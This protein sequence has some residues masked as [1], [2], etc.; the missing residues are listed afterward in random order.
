MK[1]R[2]PMRRAMLLSATFASILIG[3][4]SRIATSAIE[5]PLPPPKAT[6]C[7]V[8]KAITWSSKDT[9]ETVTEI[10]AHNARY[11]ELCLPPDRP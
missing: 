8:A 1:S 2:K 5:Q 9:A 7:A 11:D 3:C 10:K 6:F 4:T